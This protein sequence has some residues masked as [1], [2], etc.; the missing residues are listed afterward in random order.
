MCSGP[1]CLFSFLT[2]LLQ[3]QGGHLILIGSHSLRGFLLGPANL[4]ASPEL[5]SHQISACYQ[6]SQEEG[7]LSLPS[8]PFAPSGEL[9]QEKGPPGR[10]PSWGKG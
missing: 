9:C 3:G 7:G 8:P 2:R 10:E 1:S 6:P 5:L 4:L